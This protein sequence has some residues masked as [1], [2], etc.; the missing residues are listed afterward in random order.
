M[1]PFFSCVNGFI[2]QNV[3]TS[4][5]LFI[6]TVTFCLLLRSYR[7]CGVAKS[8]FYFFIV[9]VGLIDIFYY[10]LRHHV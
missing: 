7:D 4:F 6:F 8:H 5:Y 2:R 9:A 1:K 10:F 3:Y